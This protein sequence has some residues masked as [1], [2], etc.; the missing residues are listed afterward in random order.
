MEQIK[1]GSNQPLIMPGPKFNEPEESWMKRNG[2]RIILGI[3]AV[4]IIAGGIYLYNNYKDTNSPITQETQEENT[5]EI[6]PD[7]VKVGESNQT[8]QGNQTDQTGAST[9]QTLT[10]LEKAVLLKIE[11]GKVAVKAEKGAGVTHLSRK[12][13]KE[14]AQAHQDIKQNLTPEKKVYVEDYLTKKS[15]PMRVAVGQELSFDENLIKEAIDKS[16]QLSESQL[17]N[18]HKYVLLAPS[19]SA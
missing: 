16:N 13:L 4:L 15:G 8:A 1:S 11:G 14:Y 9:N 17:K 19:L 6:T 12:A 10:S 7:Q 2:Q 5:E 18:L 3:I